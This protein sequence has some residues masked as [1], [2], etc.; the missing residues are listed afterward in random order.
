MENALIFIKHN[1]SFL[2]K[3]IEL[4]NSFA[5]KIFY[6]KKIKNGLVKFTN[7]YKVN[8]NYKVKLLCTNDLEHLS[9]FIDTLDTDSFKYF[10]PHKMDKKSL[11]VTL[12]N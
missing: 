2:W 6:G 12:K 11:E 5:L 10:K 4:F 1:F 8:E 3:F 9:H 7:Y